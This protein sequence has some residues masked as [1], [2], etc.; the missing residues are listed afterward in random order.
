LKK[1]LEA[2]HKFQIVVCRS[3]MARGSYASVT[4]I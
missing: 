4:A 3:R 1:S 2:H